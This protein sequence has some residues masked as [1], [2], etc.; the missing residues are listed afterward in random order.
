QPPSAGAPGSSASVASGAAGLASGG[1]ASAPST[2]GD[3]ETDVID[4]FDASLGT[5]DPRYDDPIAQHQ[6]SLE[7][8]ESD[9]DEDAWQLTGRD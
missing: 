4:P 5:A 6:A 8:V 3:A 1:A 7:E 2:G 9:G